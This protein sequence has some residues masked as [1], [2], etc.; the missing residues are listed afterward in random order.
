MG[1]RRE[2]GGLTHP[3][4]TN[5]SSKPSRSRCFIR[6]MPR[7]RTNVVAEGEEPIAPVLHIDTTFQ[8]CSTAKSWRKREVS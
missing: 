1:D 5:K 8:R 3:R 7:A 4:N 2:M 6:V